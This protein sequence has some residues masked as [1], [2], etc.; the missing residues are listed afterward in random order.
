[1]PVTDRVAIVILNWNGAHYL[2]QF[3]P[4]VLLHSGNARVIVADNAS[5]DNSLN[6][7]ANKFKTVSVIKLP[8]NT[9]YAGGYNK[10]LATIDADIFVLLNSDIEV[11]EK[12]LEPVVDY[13]YNNQNVAAAQPLMLDYHNRAKFEY[14][15][16]AGG[17]IDFLGYPYCRGR[18]F[19]E[20]EVN[21]H[22]YDN[23]LPIFWASGACLFIKAEN[24]KMIGGFDEQFFAH[25]E[26]IDL[27]WR[28]HLAGFEVAVV[29]QAHVYHIGGG[30]LNKNNPHKTFLNYRNNLLMLHK[31]LPAHKYRNVMFWRFL[32]DYLAAFSFLFTGGF[33]YFKAVVKARQAFSRLKTSIPTY[34]GNHWPS[35]ITNSS[36]LKAYY[37]NKTKRYQDIK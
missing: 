15:G 24:F 23:V 32:L 20:L 13:L 28:L 16:A 31:N 3:L 17:F 29:P 33:T 27:C 26:E 19:N 12:W 37:L 14:A 8:T 34:K 2:E 36:I 5:T 1:M 25:Q 22:Q 35:T 4:F 10:A 7:L 11:T 6:L 30:T 18:I 21:A 9:G